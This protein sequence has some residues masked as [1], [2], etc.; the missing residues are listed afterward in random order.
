MY[1]HNRINILGQR[2]GRWTVL[3]RAANTKAGQARWICRCDCGTQATVISQSLRSDISKSC[4]CYNLENI[5]SHGQSIGGVRSREFRIWGAIKQRCLN[6]NHQS[7]KNYG[8]RGIAMCAEWENSFE[9]F[10]RDMGQCPPNCSIDRFPDNNGDYK[11]SNCRWATQAEQHRNK[12]NNHLL[13]LN[14][15]SLCIADWSER[16]SI[17]VETIHARLRQ[18]WTHEKTLTYPVTLKSGKV[19]C[20]LRS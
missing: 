20:F 15:E 13:T 12:R 2:F 14:G 7:F 11:K 6:P 9:T 18:G 16:V 19:P 3:E 10:F 17:K 1:D 5:T 4:G 8:G